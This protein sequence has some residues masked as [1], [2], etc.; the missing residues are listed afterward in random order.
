MISIIIPVYNVEKYIDDCIKSV[1][2]Q[3]YKDLEIIIVDDGS[4]DNSGKICDDW[5]KIDSRITVFHIQNS[6]L[7]AA[8]KYG[9]EHSSSNYIGFV[10][11]DDWIDSNMY[12]RLLIQLQNDDSDIVLCGLIK[13]YENGNPSI[14]EKFFLDKELY[15]KD[16][17]KNY[18]F[19]F[20]IASD[21]VSSRGIS[22]NRVTKLYRRNIIEKIIPYCDD[23]VSIGEDLLSTFA[24]ITK[25]TK[26]SVLNNFFPYHYRINENS[27][28]KKFSLEKFLKVRNLHQAML[29]INAE[30]QYDFFRQLKSDYVKLT[31]ELMDEEICFS[32]FSVQKIKKN[33]YNEYYQSMFQ[34][35]L[36][37]YDRNT[38][39][40]KNKVYLFLLKHRIILL[41]IFI[42]KKKLRVIK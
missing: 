21:K 14:C 29:K 23:D 31:L 20:A 34:D 8:W 24:A 7:M 2:C 39:N 16:E 1:I 32:D 12:E 37:Y 30:C 17:I 5:E 18:I 41:F 11:S 25:A 40:Y 13:E 33:I 3:T 4:L 6:G 36:L 42:R 38:L 19:P 28:I 26:I 27:M 15:T 10:D 9:V 35:A 22:P